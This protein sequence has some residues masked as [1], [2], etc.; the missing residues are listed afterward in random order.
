MDPDEKH[1]PRLKRKAWEELRGPL[2]AQ[3]HA[4]QVAARAA[5]L[6]TVILFEGWDAAGKGASIQVLVEALDPRGFK[7]WPIRAPRG[8][9]KAYPWLWRF[10]MKLPLRGEIAIFDRSWYS[11][12]LALDQEEERRRAYRDIV[13]LEQMLVN[14]GYALVKFWLHIEREKQRRRLK[15]RA[16]HVPAERLAE[17]WAQNRNYNAFAQLVKEML[18]KTDSPGAAW[19]VIEAADPHYTWWQVCRTVIERLSDAL[20]T[21]GVPVEAWQSQP[22]G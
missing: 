1:P 16:R 19:T 21:R 15:L 12:A 6:P 5:S 2:Q 18:D 14:D 3:L 22:T 20:R 8:E 17:S 10:W 4:L 13:E 11:Q 7:T 9:E